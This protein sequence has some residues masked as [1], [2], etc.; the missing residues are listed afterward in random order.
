MTSGTIGNEYE[1]GGPETLTLEEIERRTLQAVG[2]KRWF[3]PFPRPL[4]SLIV[5]AMEALLPAPPVTRSLLE[6]LA[7]NN[8][9]TQNSIYQ[10]V[11]QPRPFTPDNTAGYMRQFTVKQTI[12]QFMGR[13]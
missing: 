3:I 4:L 2:A 6:L 5:S 10:F 11:D 8:V 12:A 9:T 13:G 7:V 1:L